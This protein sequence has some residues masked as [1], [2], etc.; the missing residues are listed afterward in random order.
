MK[1]VSVL[2][3]GVEYGADQARF[4]HQ[5]LPGDAVCLTNLPSIKGVETLSLEYANDLHGWW[6]KME[7]FDPAGPLG[8]Q[9]LLYFDLDTVLVGDIAPLIAAV[10][11]RREIVMLSDFYHPEHPASGVMFIPARAKAR[12]W[13]AWNVN[14]YWN[15]VRRRPPGRSGDQGFIG[16]HALRIDRWED[17][18]P[19][20]IVSYKRDVLLNGG[21]VPDDALVVAFHGNPRPW[22]LTELPCKQS[23]SVTTRALN[24][25]HVSKQPSQEPQ[26]SLTRATKGRQKATARHSGS[27]GR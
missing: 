10:E 16:D 5:Q 3:T 4:L 23:S 1:I 13:R 2:R 14:P 25:S 27:R 18:C 6:A 12:I 26:P 9:D 22:S 11:G 20:A 15:M 7:L 19:G 17:L 8:D 21:V 24:G